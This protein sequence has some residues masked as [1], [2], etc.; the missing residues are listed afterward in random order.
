MLERILIAGSGGQ[1][2]IL[3][4]KLLATMAVDITEH[5]TFFPAYG[6]EVRGGTSNC[7]VILSSEEIASPVPEEFETMVVMNQASLDRFSAY[8]SD[9][10]LVLVN[11]SMCKRLPDRP[12]VSIPATEQAVEIGEDR[13]ANFIMLGAYLSRKP[14]VPAEVVKQ[15]I[16][17]AFAA[18]GQAIAD[19]NKKAFA[20]GLE[21]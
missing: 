20:I 15:T 16:D 18:K 1:G 8:M 9:D 17:H 2:I 5:I 14:L 12:V 3:L 6:A 21:L 11:A 19:L 10:N 13:A 7:Q 4:G